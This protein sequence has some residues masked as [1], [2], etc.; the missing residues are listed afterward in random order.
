MSEEKKNFKVLV[1]CMP[2]QGFKSRSRGGQ[3]WEAGENLAEITS[4]SLA[5]LREDT[6]HFIVQELSDVEFESTRERLGI[7]V[8]PAD[9]LRREND[10]LRSRIA[11]GEEAL[12][13]VEKLEGIILGV[14]EG[15]KGFADKI[16]DLA[17]KL[18]TALAAAAGT[19]HHDE[20]SKV[21]A[22]QKPPA[23]PKS[24]EK[25]PS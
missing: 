11:K 4:E 3:R 13:R 25:K 16:N 18:E 17:H 24:D 6:Q 20:A 1:R 23:K 19:A 9:T 10:D 2:A 21:E 14:E 22:S 12:A 8:D 5:S 7:Q 15:F